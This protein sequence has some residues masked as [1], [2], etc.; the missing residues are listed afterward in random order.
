MNTI[1]RFKHG[2]ST[3][4]NLDKDFNN[5]KKTSS[6]KKDYF[7]ISDKPWYSIPVEP[8]RGSMINV[9]FRVDVMAKHCNNGLNSTAY[10]SI[11]DC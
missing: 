1:L 6:F 10:N 5:F 7:L 11:T 4:R 9:T 8:H 3:E 2:G